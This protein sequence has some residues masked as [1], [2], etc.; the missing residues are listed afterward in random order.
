M[1]DSRF[2]P[3]Q[4]QALESAYDKLG[5]QF[6]GVLIVVMASVDAEGSEQAQESVRCYYAG[7]RTLAVGLASEA[8]HTIQNSVPSRPD[9]EP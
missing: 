9:S 1:T 3:A 2:T 8:H 4:Q 7:G 5:E 6:D